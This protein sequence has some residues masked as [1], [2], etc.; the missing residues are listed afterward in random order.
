MTVK[1]S[2][3]CHELKKSKR[4]HLRILVCDDVK[5]EIIIGLAFIKAYSHNT[6]PDYNA[7]EYARTKIATRTVELG[8]G[9]S[10]TYSSNG[11]K[12]IVIAPVTSEERRIYAEREKQ[13]YKRNTRGTAVTW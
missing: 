1:I 8:D 2:L 12:H 10:M 6:F 4:M 5:T 7:A 9:V 11:H 13:G 3:M